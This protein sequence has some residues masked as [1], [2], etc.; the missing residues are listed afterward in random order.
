M[1]KTHGNPLDLS[2]K[3]WVISDS[4]PYK[5]PWQGELQLGAFFEFVQG[6]FV[7]VLHETLRAKKIATIH[8]L[9]HSEI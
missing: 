9:L 4:G 8:R 7:T 5:I 3:P 2:F 1:D 6:Y